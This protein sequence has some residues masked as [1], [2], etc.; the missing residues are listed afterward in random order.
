MAHTRQ[1]LPRTARRR[2][3][4]MLATLPLVCLTIPSLSVATPA[5]ASTFV[6]AAASPVRICYTTNLG[7]P[8][9]SALAKLMKQESAYYGFQF[10]TFDIHNDIPTQLADLE[11]CVTQHYSAIVLQPYDPTALCPAVE[12]AYKAHIPM[13]NIANPLSKCTQYVQSFVTDNGYAEGTTSGML[14]TQALHGKGHVIMIQGLLNNPIV[15]GRTNGF[16]DYLKAHA[17]GLK[18]IATGEGQ[19]NTAVTESV[20]NAY[21][22]RFGAS[23]IQG[24]YAMDS[25]TAL[26]VIESLKTHGL[27][28]NAACGCMTGSG[29]KIFVTSINGSNQE[30][31]EI[32][33][34]ELYGTVLNSAVFVARNAIQRIRDILDHVPVLRNYVMPA[35]GITLANVNEFNFYW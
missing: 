32:R 1:N 22:T 21:L 27:T 4:A 10:N 25:G 7:D 11:N 17:P 15:P 5:S 31:A 18:M 19:W 12:L 23:D 29:A 2:M 13:V 20:M 16:L 28:P 6:P 26:G 9:S 8:Y 35:T 14:M 24:V 30:G 3:L 34:G 33:A